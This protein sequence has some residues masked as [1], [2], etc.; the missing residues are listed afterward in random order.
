MIPLPFITIPFI[1]AISFLNGQYGCTSFQILDF[2]D[3]QPDIYAHRVMLQAIFFLLS[4][5]LVFLYMFLL[6]LCLC[7]SLLFLSLCLCYGCVRIA[8]L[9]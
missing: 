9:L 4:H 5:I 2:I 3:S 1:T 8:N 6:H 7:S